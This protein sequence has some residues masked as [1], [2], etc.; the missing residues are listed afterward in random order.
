MSAKT[1]E[2]AA[3]G[4]AASTRRNGVKTFLARRL[5]PLLRI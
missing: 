5:L 4:K 1:F 2:K 3:T